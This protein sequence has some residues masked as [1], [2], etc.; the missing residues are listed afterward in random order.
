MDT[1]CG[2]HIA[3]RGI[4]FLE[5]YTANSVPQSFLARTPRRA[6]CA[7]EAAPAFAATARNAMICNVPGMD[8]IRQPLLISDSLLFGD[9]SFGCVSNLQHLGNVEISL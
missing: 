6:W 9:A 2:A 4:S 7:T 5:P 3:W 1:F 8:S